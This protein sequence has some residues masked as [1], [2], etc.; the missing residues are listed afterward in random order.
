M[1]EIIISAENIESTPI[2]KEAGALP[3]DKIIDGYFTR[4]LSKDRDVKGIVISQ[5]NID[6][7]P[8]LQ[9]AEAKVGDRI[10]DG[11]L[12]RGEEATNL[13]NLQYGFGATDGLA[14]GAFDYLKSEFPLTA[15]LGSIGFDYARSPGTLGFTYDA[16]SET[17]GPDFKDATPEERREII[18]GANIKNLREEFPAGFEP[19]KDSL[20]YK[21][22]EVAGTVFDVSSLL[23]IGQSYK[24]VTGISAALGAGA[25]IIEDIKQNKPVDTEKATWYAGGAAVLGPATKFGIDK[26][27]QK[28]ASRV[29][30]KMNKKI[31][32]LTN[33]GQEITPQDI[34]KIATD[35]GYSDKK[36][37][38]AYRILNENPNNSIVDLPTKAAN[39]A[40][41]EDSAV[42]RK[43]SGALEEYL[44]IL[45]TEIRKISV[46]IFARVRLFEYNIATKTQNNLLQA[47][48]F[49][50][51]L[52]KV[53]D[54]KTYD[55]VA[56]HLN[57]GRFNEVSNILKGKKIT[58]QK[59]LEGN[60]ISETKVINMLDS[61]NKVKPVL[62]N[63]GEELKNTHKINPY[64]IQ[65]Y[66]PRVVKDYG[67]LVNALGRERAGFFD[68]QLEV[69]AKK[70]NIMKEDIPEAVEVEI[71]DNAV[72]GYK[73]DTSGK[74]PSFIKE[75]KIENVT[76]DLLE[77]YHEPV[78]ALQLY[79]RGAVNNIERSKFFGKSFDLGKEGSVGSWIKKELPKLDYNDQQK[80][81]TLLER[82]FIDGEKSGSWWSQAY[83]NIGYAGTIANPIAAATQIGDLG[84][85]GFK[86]GAMP[87]LKAAMPEIFTF[88]GP[89]A[90]LI[91][92]GLDNV[93]ATEISNATK[94]SKAL[95]TLFKLSGFKSIDKFGKETFINAALRK[96][97][98]QVK[99]KKGLK[100]I[101]EKW[102]E[103]FGDEM[104]PLIADLQ[105]G[106]MSENVK[107]LLFNELSDVQPIS[108]SE[109][110][111]KYLQ[112]TDGRLFYMLKS[113]TLKQIDVIRRDI[114]QR[115]AKKGIMNK[116]AA[117]GDA[118]RLMI[119]LGGANLGTKTVKDMMLGRD[120]DLDNIGDKFV[121]SFFGVYGIDK[122]GAERFM[123]NGKYIDRIA[124]IIMPAN[125]TLEGLASAAVESAKEEPKTQKMLKSTIKNI[126]VLGNIMYHWF[127]GGIEEYNE[128]LSKSY[129]KD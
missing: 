129:L 101:Q 30:N 75:R 26:A 10:I 88:T 3:G 1:P 31:N 47:Q 105:A 87:T 113:F 46:P 17:Y 86:N 51:N 28:S 98:T 80:L 25:S 73:V 57:N 66:F 91:D 5:E 94:F 92:L 114:I 68:K 37:Q 71:L 35:L 128:K 56:L 7:T 16:P 40:I 53:L 12:V 72:R 69:Y 127:L 79:I 52:P 24:A 61:F 109:M 43:Q 58:V 15:Y 22:G 119:F 89:K 23:P 77:F 82:R 50:E 34:S 112:M 21:T 76:S 60:K 121:W 118:L 64:K 42:S 20:A 67:G 4:V 54:K 18:M 104:K 38:R 36:V 65:N 9:E 106:K 126:P 13:Q 95:N 85:S 19:D 11:E 32:D 70:Q 120:Q 115:G 102:G 97:Q 83:K 45:S 111:A 108:L 62:K 100:K 29:V 103:V 125:P 55:T 27:I 84:L 78:D 41:T 110:P 8:L 59:F 96:S 81:Q 14:S 93:I 44:G 39:K 116:V 90:R 123:Q 74:T 2:L 117:G 107:L 63:L 49:I 48:D 6:S 99:S 33:L 124:D 122:Y